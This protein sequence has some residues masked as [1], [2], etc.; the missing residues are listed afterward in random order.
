M[1][2]R[3][4]QF[5]IAFGN[6]FGAILGSISGPILDHFGMMMMMMMMVMMMMRMKMKKMIMMTALVVVVL[7]ITIMLGC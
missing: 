5:K 4:L 6:D 1:L 3:R 7:M 2:P